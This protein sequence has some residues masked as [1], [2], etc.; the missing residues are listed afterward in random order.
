MVD[1]KKII[2]KTVCVILSLIIAVFAV[3]FGIYFSDLQKT[4]DVTPEWKETVLNNYN[5]FIAEVDG[6]PNK[7]PMVVTTDQHGAIAADSE[8]YAYFNSIVDW[9]KVSKIINLGDTVRNAYNLLELINYGKATEC[10]PA[11]KRIEVIGNHDRFFVP[12]GKNVEKRFFDNPAAEYSS[13]RKAFVINDE[14]YG[15]RYLA[16]DT[17]R[18][19]Y[20]YEHGELW[21]A[22]ADFI[23]KELEKDDASDIVML[24]HPYIFKDAVINRSGGTF[25]GSEWFIGTSSEYTDVKQSFIDMLA[26]RKNKTVGVLIDCEGVEHPYDFTNCKGD[27]LMTLHGHHHTEGYE[28]KDG[29]TEFLFQSMTKDNADNTEPG[30]T[31]FAYI[32]RAAKTFKCWKNLPGYEAWEFPIA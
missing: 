24:S 31:Y 15:I 11:E 23:I 10:L 29:I 12:T 27:F 14:E 7:I 8:V 2:K 21:T 28:T 13:D 19:P 26:A 1:L 17:K 32:D 30:V 6:D 20:N 18:F 25:T 4:F 16:V 22:Q 9:N 3:N 5:E